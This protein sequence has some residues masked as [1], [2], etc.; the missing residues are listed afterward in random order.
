MNLLKIKTKNGFTLLETM[1]GMGVLSIA[2]LAFLQ[3]SG[4]Y[5]V[6]KQ[7]LKERFDRMAF[8]QYVGILLNDQRSCTETLKG[9]NPSTTVALTNGIKRFLAPSTIETLIA[10]TSTETIPALFSHA[11]DNI[12]VG[13]FLSTSASGT[14]AV[15][16]VDINIYVRHIL[17]AGS[18][19]Y[20]VDPG[21]KASRKT[22]K[23]YVVTQAGIIQSC[24]TTSTCDL[25]GGKFNYTTSQC[26]KISVPG[27]I[28]TATSFCVNG[29]CRNFSAS[30]DCTA[31]Q[32][33]YGIKADGTLK[34]KALP[35]TVP[36]CGPGEYVHTYDSKTNSV[37]CKPF[38]VV[39]S[40]CA[41]GQFISRISGPLASDVTCTPAPGPTGPMGP[42][43][44]AGPVGDTGATGPTGPK[45][46]KGATGA[47]GPVGP[48]GPQG[49][50]G[51]RGP[52]GPGGIQG[53][54]GG[55]GAQGPTG[56]RGSDRSC[57]R[58]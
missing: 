42:P 48:V 19:T 16:W 24:L 14:M 52:T 35:T 9:L 51:D 25:V 47:Q 54:T 15:G 53:P 56:P 41:P 10:R 34:C 32:M 1:V 39:G 55:T 20:S 40:A 11:V 18:G 22:Y 45:G 58:C 23:A 57:N 30:N 27:N 3:L 44:P 37:S 2:V 8:H 38:K 43:G 33:A 46:L 13:N 50:Q 49:V 26:D 17:K 21:S 12:T 6:E 29:R 36:S 5:N 4:S 7:N 28:T 31:S